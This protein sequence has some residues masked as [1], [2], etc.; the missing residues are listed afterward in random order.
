MSF[1]MASF[2]QF[3]L[4]SN[5]G[6]LLDNFLSPQIVSPITFSMFFS[7]SLFDRF[8]KLVFIILCNLNN[9]NKKMQRTWGENRMHK[10]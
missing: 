6:K 4:S 9:Q 10:G 8:N 7:Q 1:P 2:F 3:N 5:A